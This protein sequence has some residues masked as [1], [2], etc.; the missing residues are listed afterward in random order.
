MLEN[1]RQANSPPPSPPS[2]HEATTGD[3]EG[4]LKAKIRFA[5]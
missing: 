1:T 2:Q 4:A 3:R 5:I